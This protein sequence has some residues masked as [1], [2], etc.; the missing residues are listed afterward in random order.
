M[1][2]VTLY[3]TTV[4]GALWTTPE[5]AQGAPTSGNDAPYAT[6]AIG[7]GGTSALTAA[8]AAYTVPGTI[9]AFSAVITARSNQTDTEAV[10]SHADLTFGS[11]NTAPQTNFGL[12]SDSATFN[13][14]AIKAAIASG[15]SGL[16]CTFTAG[17]AAT[18]DAK[19]LGITVTYTPTGGG[20]GS[21]EEVSL[22][23]PN[24]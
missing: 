19:G 15:L 22:I 1:A 9:T 16:A 18:V 2:T 23:W 8:F 14:A 5:N 7:G 4:T 17:A 13:A 10:F 12:V 20:A 21:P 11:V 6:D 24:E 3:A